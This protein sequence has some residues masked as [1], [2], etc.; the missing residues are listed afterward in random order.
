MCPTCGGLVLLSTYNRRYCS[1]RCRRAAQYAKERDQH[2]TS[3][4]AN[5]TEFWNAL[6]DVPTLGD[7]TIP[8]HDKLAAK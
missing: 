4:A 5:W 1:I 7:E 2:R 6:G 3:R 8:T